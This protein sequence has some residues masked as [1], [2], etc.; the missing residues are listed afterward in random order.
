MDAAVVGIGTRRG[1]GHDKRGAGRQVA[2]GEPSVVRCNGVGYAA[3]IHPTDLLPRHDRGRARGA[4]RERA[5]RVDGR[6]RS[7]ARTTSGRVGAWAVGRAA[8]GSRGEDEGRHEEPD[9]EGHLWPPKNWRAV[10]DAESRPQVYPGGSVSSAG[11]LAL[12]YGVTVI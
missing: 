1:K 9:S 2:A 10:M 5:S 4:E 11:A 7:S 6:A 8:T 3:V 12:S